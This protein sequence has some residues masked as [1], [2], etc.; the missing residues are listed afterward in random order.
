MFIAW[1]NLDLGFHTCFYNGMDAY[2]QTWL[3]LAFPMYVWFLISVI[4]LTSRHSVTVTKLMGSNPVAVLATLLLMSY[5][6]VLKIIIEVYSSVDLNY[7]DNKTRTV[8]LKDANVP[9]LQSWHLA[10]AVVITLI[11]IFLFLPYTLLLLLGYKLYWVFGRKYSRWL[12]RIKPFLDSYYAPYKMHTRYWTGLLLL[13]RCALYM[14]FSFNSLGATTNSLLGINI[15]LAVAITWLSI[16]V[17]SN[18]YTNVVEVVVYSNLITLSSANLAGVNSQAL[19][20]FLVGMVLAIMMGIIMYHFHVL[21]A[22]KS[23]ALL[24]KLKTIIAAGKNMS[25][26]KSLL[27]P[28]DNSTPAI[29]TKSFVSVD[30]PCTAYCELNDTIVN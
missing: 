9:Y 20:N 23:A 12:N 22:K 11:L 26:T 21:T 1:M 14:L 7:P 10:L 19:V 30:E 16:K 3:Q 24:A 5:T 4:I 17:Y 29:V 18:F 2:T 27:A 28:V 15:A 8:W 6:K 25:E 13:I